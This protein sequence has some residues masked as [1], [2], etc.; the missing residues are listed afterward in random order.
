[1][2]VTVPLANGET[3]I[4]R[5]TFASP[6]HPKGIAQKNRLAREGLKKTADQEQ[7]MLNRRKVKIEAETPE[8]MDRGN[9]EFVVERLLGW[10]A[11]LD[12]GEDV[13]LGGEPF[14][15][16]QDNARKL[17]SMPSMWKLRIQA[18]EF[19]GDAESFTKRSAKT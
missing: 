13:K 18:A 2:K 8:E 1:M 5:W 10:D 14:P 12:N 19:I 11:K 16:S 6:S 9:V 15:F 7:Q 17:L 3:T 4:G